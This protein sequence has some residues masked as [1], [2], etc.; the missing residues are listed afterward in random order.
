MNKL[1]KQ[2]LKEMVLVELSSVDLLNEIATKS[3]RKLF[4]PKLKKEIKSA[5]D[6]KNFKKAKSLANI[7]LDDKYWTGL[8]KSVMMNDVQRTEWYDEI[9][10]SWKTKAQW[11]LDQIKKKIKAAKKGLPT[12]SQPR[13]G[14]EISAVLP[15]E[16]ESKHPEVVRRRKLKL[17]EKELNDSLDTYGDI[18]D[19]LA[20]CPD[21]DCDANKVTELKK[22]KKNIESEIALLR[23]RIKDLKAGPGAVGAAVKKNRGKRRIGLRRKHAF[24][25]AADFKKLGGTVFKNFEDFYAEVAK[26]PEAAKALCRFRDDKCRLRNKGRDKRWGRSHWEAWGILTQPKVTAAEPAAGTRRKREPLATA[27]KNF[28]FSEFDKHL[29]T[30]TADQLKMFLRKLKTMKS[31]GTRPENTEYLNALIKHIE[32]KWN[33]K[34]IPTADVKGDTTFDK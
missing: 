20:N 19:E 15:P 26:N 7:F 16:S 13:R 14:I 11:V 18:Q 1:T 34:P 10:P 5:F 22:D 25:T 32:K 33:E 12:A 29:A 9:K 27:K 30:A 21:E 8:E 3:A 24:P 31:K 2:I 23:A 28:N 17:A 6:A 4:P